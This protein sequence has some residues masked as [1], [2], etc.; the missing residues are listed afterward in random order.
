MSTDATDPGPKDAQPSA[1][2]PTVESLV[3]AIE[4]V[5]TQGVAGL[6]D[7]G[8]QGAI[9]ADADIR[10][11][12]VAMNGAGLVAVISIL[13]TSLDPLAVR[14]AVALYFVGLAAALMS[15]ALRVR[16]H[17][18][19]MLADLQIAVAL[20]TFKEN[21]AVKLPLNTKEDVEVIGR[22]A[23]RFIERATKALKKPGNAIGNWTWAALICFFL[24]TSLLVVDF[25]IAGLAKPKTP[26]PLPAITPA[27][28]VPP[29]SGHAKAAH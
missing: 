3:A 29:S 1:E 19:I 22:V 28:A 6:S 12:L 8:R 24:A 20:K 25:E 13:S 2:P 4:P 16:F 9:A 17:N 23:T 11:G 26:L 5:L 7:M 27:V 18:S 10:R 21:P 15:W 14:A